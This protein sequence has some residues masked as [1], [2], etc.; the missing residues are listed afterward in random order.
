MSPSRAGAGGERGG[1]DAECGA[2]SRPQSSG[3]GPP[4]APMRTT[5]T[6]ASTEVPRK[7]GSVRH[8]QVGHRADLGRPR[9]HRSGVA[10]PEDGQRL[11]Q[12]HR[13]AGHDEVERPV[14]ERRT[15]VGV[16]GEPAAL[17]RRTALQLTEERRVA[18]DR[19]EPAARPGVE[20]VRHP[21]PRLDLRGR[22]R[23]GPRPAAAAG[24]SGPPRR[25][26]PSRAPRGRPTRRAAATRKCPVPHAGSSTRAVAGGQARSRIQSTRSGGV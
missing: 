15:G 17:A 8:P 12:G 13:P 23:T 22:R 14:E 2:A 10:R 25:R 19:V 6:H 1:R 9:A 21:H 4:V 26:G 16:G 3:P 20:P 18:D 24:R 11:D 7:T 5:G